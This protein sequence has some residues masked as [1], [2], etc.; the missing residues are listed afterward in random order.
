[1]CDAGGVD[2]PAGATANKDT[3]VL[4]YVAA[5]CADIATYARGPGQVNIAADDS[6]MAADR[7]GVLDIGIT[8][9]HTDI[10]A[11]AGGPDQVRVAADDNKISANLPFQPQVVA[12]DQQI[13]ADEF[14]LVKPHISA[15]KGNITADL[16]VTGGA[17][18]LPERCE[19]EHPRSYGYDENEECPA[20]SPAY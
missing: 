18:F 17:Q 3:R 11:D 2:A 13:A 15:E 10:A 1:V 8:A 4:I 12:Y 9:D 7:G 14:V 6:E 16:P 20:S 5:E 19:Q